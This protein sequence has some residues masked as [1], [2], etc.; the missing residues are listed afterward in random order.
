MDER[1][2]VITMKEKPLT[3]LGPEIKIG[4]K[5][6]DFVLID[7]ELDEVNLADFQD[8]YKVISVTQSLD[9]SVCDMQARRF[10]HEAALLPG[11]V[12]VLNVS[13]DLPFAISRFCSVAGIKNVIVLSD[14]RDASFGRAYGVLIKEQRL[15]ARSVFIIDKADIVRYC[16]IVSEQS[17]YPDYDKALDALKSISK[18]KKAA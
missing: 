13:M 5:A 12:A 6:P 18:V 16:E 2:G 8:K 11:D 9:T 15:L 14:H 4:D 17:H 7:Q 1:K 3:L 10:N